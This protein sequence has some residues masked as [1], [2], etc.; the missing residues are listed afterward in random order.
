MKK[1]FISIIVMIL[2]LFLALSVSFV[3]RQ[4]EVDSSLFSDLYNKKQAYYN[5]QSALNIYLAENME[6]LEDD[7]K[8]NRIDRSRNTEI[9]KISYDGES[10]PVRIEYQKD[11]KIPE[12]RNTY[13]VIVAKARK[14]SNASARAFLYLNNSNKIKLLYKRAN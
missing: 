3:A 10:Y 7:I 6:K 9:G 2:L 12:H 8:N 14:G 11:S 5:C 13:V 1:G 4:N